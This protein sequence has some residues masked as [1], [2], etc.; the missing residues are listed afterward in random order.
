MMD[1]SLAL[2]EGHRDMPALFVTP[3]PDLEDEQVIAEIHHVRASLADLVRVPKRWN[4]LLRRTSTA[5]AIQG[6][7]TIGG[8]T[9]SERT[10]SLRLTT[11]L[12]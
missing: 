7:N 5:R 12:R 10:P 6:S 11:S 9:V 4:G 8:Y 1:E 3:D 2:N